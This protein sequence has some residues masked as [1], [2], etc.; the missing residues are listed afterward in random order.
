ML[1]FGILNVVSLI[2]LSAVVALIMGLDEG[3][4]PRKVAR[5]SLGCW[6]KLLGALVGIGLLVYLLSLFSG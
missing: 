5:Q 2:Y 3:E 6:A 1:T 4:S